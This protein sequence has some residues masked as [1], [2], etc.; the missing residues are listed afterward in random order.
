MRVKFTADIYNAT[1]TEYIDI[2]EYDLEHV[3]EEDK[4]DFIYEY[5][6]NDIKNNISLYIEE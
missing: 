6:F 5:I 3:S 2:P 1:I 4:E